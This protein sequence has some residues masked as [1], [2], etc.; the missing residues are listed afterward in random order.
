MQLSIELMFQ[1]LHVFRQCLAPLSAIPCI[2]SEGR[3]AYRVTYLN[4]SKKVGREGLVVRKRMGIST[5]NWVWRKGFMRGLK[6]REIV[7]VCWIVGFQLPQQAHNSVV[8]VVVVIW[9]VR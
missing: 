4:G 2:P 6:R 7:C 1:E 9:M 8:V 5:L 3:L